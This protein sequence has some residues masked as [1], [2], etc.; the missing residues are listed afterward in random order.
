MGILGRVKTLERKN[1]SK[2]VF[3]E[4]GEILWLLRSGFLMKQSCVDTCQIEQISVGLT[5]SGRP[6]AAWC[7]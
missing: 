6:P 5:C 7:P 1:L 2:K 3:R 4:K